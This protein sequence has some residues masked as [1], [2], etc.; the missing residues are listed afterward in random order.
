MH[1][2]N[3]KRGYQK[4]VRE[5]VIQVISEWGGQIVEPPYYRNASFD[6]FR[7]AMNE[8][9]GLPELRRQKLKDKI[10]RG[11]IVKVIVTY[12]GISALLA[13]KTEVETENGKKQFD[14][15]WMSSLCDSTIKGK[16][17]IELVDISSRV[18]VVN[19]IMEITTKPIIFDADT[20]G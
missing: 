9:R 13:E 10:E 19:D 20:G 8:L 11:E 7:G 4:K 6:Y 18:S 14:A 5:R 1:G 12:D 17:D 3:W 2:D 15:L 16:P